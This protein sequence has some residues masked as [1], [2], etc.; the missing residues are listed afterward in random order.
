MIYKMPSEWEEKELQDIII[1]NPDERLE[2]GSMVKR[3]NLD[4]LE[5]CHKFIRGF[6][7]VE[8]T[9]GGSK[10]RNNDVLFPKISSALMNK[11]TALVTILDQDEVGV[12]S[13]WY[14]VLRAVP[15]ITDPDFLYYLAITPWFRELAIRA[16]EGSSRSQYISLPIFMKSRFHIPPYQ[17]Q[18]S[19]ARILSTI[20]NKIQKNIEVFNRL[21]AVL[22]QLFRDWFIDFNFPNGQGV[23]YK[24]NGGLLY[25]SDLGNIPEGWIAGCLSD[26]GEIV[27][28]ATPSKKNSA[29]YVTD[30]GIPWITPKDLSQTKTKYISRGA[31]N[32]SN[33]GYK[34]SGVT[35]LPAGTVLFSS[36]APIGYI[37]IAA[38]ELTTNQ[39]FRSIIPKD[40]IGS[41][42]LYYLLSN[43]TE[44]ITN[45]ASGTTFQE[46]SGS[47]LK[48]LRVIIPD[49]CVLQMFQ[50]KTD[51]LI[52]YQKNVEKEN[53]LLIAIRDNLLPL[54]MSG[55]VKI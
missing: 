28:G 19:I 26:L 21:E 46:I 14:M 53:N 12:G 31:D 44:E 6:D 41:S 7:R 25:E 9:G 10:F 11:K 24:Q 32:I 49:S 39:G 55:E 13:N 51:Y 38:N 42:Y 45:M 36:R 2:K 50:S 43:K 17:E 20:D 16:L 8:Y 30:G 3:I 33:E 1:F 4:K 37:A 52:R 22:M 18:C 35:L 23:P 47:A 54:L 29:F 5:P 34:S 15:Q 40:G 27:S 48:K